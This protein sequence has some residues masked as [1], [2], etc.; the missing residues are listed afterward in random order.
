MSSDP[1]MCPWC[2]DNAGTPPGG[3]NDDCYS[4]REWEEVA[5]LNRKTGMLVI[6]Y[7]AQC[8]V[9]GFEM[10]YKIDV[11]MPVQPPK[12]ELFLPLEF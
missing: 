7:Y 8:P 3:W 1:M 6:D 11:P 10:E 5:Y 2:A 9:C 4:L 12:E